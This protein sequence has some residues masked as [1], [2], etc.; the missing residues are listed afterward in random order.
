[1]PTTAPL[2]VLEFIN[3]VLKRAGQATVATLVAA[4]TPVRQTLDALNLVYSELLTTLPFPQLQQ[5]LSLTVAAGDTN[6]SLAPLGITPVALVSGGF[7]H[8]SDAQGNPV[9]LTRLSLAEAL[10]RPR[11]S[12]APQP[13]S[14]WLDADTLVLWPTPQ[15]SVSLVLR[16]PLSPP[17]YG[18]SDASTPI[19]FPPDWYRVLLLGVLAHVQQFL[20]DGSYPLTFQVFDVAR[21]Q[22]KAKFHFQ[23]TPS[24]FLGRFVGWQEGDDGFGSPPSSPPHHN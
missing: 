15:A 2:T 4:Q 13:T 24:R 3:L 10:R 11:N 14:Y 1:M 23:Q 9:S 22:L 17:R 12:T 8:Y 16:Y 19:P 6:V 18:E 21:Q 20:G 7:V 5:T